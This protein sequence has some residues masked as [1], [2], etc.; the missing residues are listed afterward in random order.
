MPTVK[1]QRRV[2]QSAGQD[3]IATTIRLTPDIDSA[4]TT[5]ALRLGLTRSAVVR[6]A[7]MAWDS[8]G[9]QSDLSPL[10]SVGR[11]SADS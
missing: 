3:F 2:P 4:L 7:L 8:D 11:S 6:L 5:E 9:S 10:A 1:R